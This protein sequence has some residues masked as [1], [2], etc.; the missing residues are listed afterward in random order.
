MLRCGAVPAYVFVAMSECSSILAV[1]CLNDW[2]FACCVRGLRSESGI[3]QEVF[4]ADS[5]VLNFGTGAYG[6]SRSEMLPFVPTSPGVCLEVGCYAGE[7][8]ESVINRGGVGEYWALE[9]NGKVAAQA[10]K[11]GVDKIVEGDAQQNIDALPSGYFDTVICNDILE[12]L[13]DPFLFMDSMRRTLKPGATVIASLPN[14]RYH[15]NLKELL[16]GRQWQYKDE[17]I[18]DRTHL[19]FFTELS[20]RAL[21]E[22]YGYEIQ[23]VTGINGSRSHWLKL[24]SWMTFGGTQDLRYL[25]FAVVAKSPD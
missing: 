4:V 2:S 14:V 11:R 1:T 20:L 17:G 16:F 3:Y 21:F 8:A 6:G 24:L 9:W 5:Q 25:Q 18:L 7:F 23:E 13:V 22:P 12:H 19:R 10:R 15:R